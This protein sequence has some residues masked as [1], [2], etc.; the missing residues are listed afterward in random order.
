MIYDNI[1][2]GCINNDRKCQK[3][4][5]DLFSEQMYAVCSRY[6]RDEFDAQESM[7]KG[8]IKVFQKIAEY[9]NDGSFEGWIRKIMVR[10]ALNQIATRRT[11]S[12]EELE[13]ENHI[14]IKFAEN[15]TYETLLKLIDRLPEGYAMVFNLYVLDELKHAEIAQLLNIS[16][17]TSRSQL[18]KGKKLL[19]SY[20]DQKLNHYL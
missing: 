5:Y 13:L 16:E 20:F 17:S 14:S 15:M 10:S 3:L 9:R 19:R 8:F 11:I 4:L 6:C 1:I 2:Q 12:F 18:A 7:Q